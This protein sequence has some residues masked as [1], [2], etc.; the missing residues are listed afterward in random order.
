MYDV[1]QEW[2]KKYG[3]VHTFWF[4]PDPIVAITDYK[5]IE[6][7]FL[8]DGDTFAGRPQNQDLFE[9]TRSELEEGTLHF[10]NDLSNCWSIEIIFEINSAFLGG[11][12]GIILTQE[13]LW[14]DQRRF[15]LHTLRDFGFGKNI[16]Q[17]RVSLC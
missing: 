2:T 13:D 11:M 8:K 7:T 9:V 15:A 12:Y 3:P 1:F 6:E 5:L 16:M 4:G 14:R 10:W 17:E